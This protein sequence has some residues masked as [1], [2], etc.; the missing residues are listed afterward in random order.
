[1]DATRFTAAVRTPAGTHTPKHPR[2]RDRKP[3]PRHGLGLLVVLFVMLAVVGATPY[4]GASAPLLWRSQDGTPAAMMTLTLVPDADAQVSEDNP[5]FNYGARTELLVNGGADPDVVSYLRF[6]VSGVTAPVQ[7][8]TLRLWVRENGSTRDGP[9]LYATDTDWTETDLT[10]TT[11]PAAIGG[12]LDDTETLASSTWV[13]YDVTA[14]VSGDGPIAFVLVAPSADGVIFHSR[15][16]ENPPQLVLIIGDEPPT[17]TPKPNVTPAAGSD[18]TLLAAGDIADCDSD[19]DEAT[20]ALLD[21]LPGIVA[22]LGDTVYDS[23]T[24]QEFAQ[25]YEPTWG[26][27][28]SRTRPAVGNHEY[29]TSG[30]SGYFGYFSPEVLTSYYSYE[31]GAWHIVALDSNCSKVGGCH[32]DSPQ[33]QWLREDLAANPTACTLAYWHHPRFSFGKYDDNE[34]TR[35][36]WQVLAEHGAEIVLT[37]HDHNYQRYAPQTS[38]GARDDARGIRQFVV[39]TGGK[40][41]YPLDTPPPNVEAFNDETFGIL[42]LTLRP[43]GYEWSFIPIAGQSFT[44]T[45][46]GTCH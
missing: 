33:E 39:G 15:E 34:A 18:P 7:R 21:H 10:W 43:T 46:N 42:Q 40:N 22:A 20:A 5:D 16:G 44:D 45:G 37:G 26:R 29:L 35:R 23:G 14:A 25:C 19:G 31:L 28:K 38:T 4:L 13:E 27:H 8:A 32:Q 24:A 36:L 41:H 12:A 9:A 6:D 17:P 2:S 1:M 11:Q 3:S 30:A